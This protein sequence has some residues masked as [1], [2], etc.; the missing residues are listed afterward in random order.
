MDTVIIKIY[1]PNKFKIFDKSQFVPEIESRK[2]SELSETEK[3]S[4]LTRS[5]LRHFVLHPKWQEEYLPRVEVFEAL[6]E[7]RRNI[8]YILKIE[9]SVPKLLYWNSLEEVSENDKQKVFSA[10]KLAL[11]RVGIEVDTETIT[12]A[13]VSAV[14]ACKNILLPKEIRMREIIN[15]LSKIDVTKSFDVSER[16]CK[17]GARVLNIYSGTIDSSFY[18]KISDSLRPK[19]KRSDKSRI[20]QERAVIDLYNLQDREVFR[21]EYRIKKNQTVKREV[22]AL[23]KRDYKTQVVFK[24]LFTPDLMKSLILN[25]WQALI[26]RPENQLS[27]FGTI[28][29]LGLFLH[30]LSEA[31][32]QSGKAHSINNALISYGLT[33]LMRDHGAKEVKGAIFDVW[34][35][36]HPERLTKKIKLASEL[37]KGLSYSSNI[38]FIDAKLRKYELITLTSLQNEI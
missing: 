23:L 34:D 3:A 32:R 1:G 38:A 16:Q 28:D 24:D 12:N 18:D 30:I 7:D 17:K 36:N 22:N 6:T 21:Y 25:S 37:T 20:E 13:T 9:F 8:R 29:K 35:T 11:K 19:N 27:L 4:P 15:E 31:K 33:T 10:L 2:Y 26:Q 14:H 5:Y